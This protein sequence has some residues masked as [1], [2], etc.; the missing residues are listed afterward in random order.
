LPAK[1][2]LYFWNC[3]M[4]SRRHLWCPTTPGR[5]A[6]RPN[7]PAHAMGKQDMLPILD[8]FLGTPRARGT[9]QV[10]TNTLIGGTRLLLRSLRRF[11]KRVR[12]GL[13]F[14]T[15]VDARQSQKRHH[16]KTAQNAP[17]LYHPEIDT[18]LPREVW[19]RS[20]RDL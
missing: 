11:V 12:L 17:R 14:P 4:S 13:A 3:T 2:P 18:I 20:N 6:A 10:Y 7:I 16:V 1:R 5:F 19:V 8:H 15:R 9:R